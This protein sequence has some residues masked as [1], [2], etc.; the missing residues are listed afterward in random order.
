VKV[1]YLRFCDLSEENMVYS[2]IVKLKG[3][4]K[5]VPVSGVMTGKQVLID[6]PN[7][8]NHRKVAI[9]SG[10]RDHDRVI[11]HGV[12]G[13]YDLANLKTLVVEYQELDGDFDALI[14]R[15]YLTLAYAQWRTAIAKK[16]V[17]TGQIVEFEI[18]R[19]N[20]GVFR[21]EM[22][23]V[24]SYDFKMYT[25]EEVNKLLDDFLDYCFD[26]A[27]MSVVYREKLEEWKLRKL[28]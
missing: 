27:E 2:V 26:D 25:F 13:E 18:V 10:Y 3:I 20:A 4:I 6:M 11:L 24:L 19:S 23:K 12:R 9:I 22:A 17:D 28:N 5:S 21:I 1:V 8:T 14:S 7:S 16:E 15:D